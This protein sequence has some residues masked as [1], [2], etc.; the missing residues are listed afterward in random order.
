MVA[1]Y[2]GRVRYA[3]ENFGDSELAERHGV[4]EYPAVFVDDELFAAPQ[5]FHPWAA[6]L[7]GRYHPWRSPES[8]RRFQDELRKA[9]DEALA[10]E[11]AETTAESGSG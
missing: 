1:E 8:H 6:G 11:R 5:E 2:G 9:L 10:E 4:K 7:A 3:D